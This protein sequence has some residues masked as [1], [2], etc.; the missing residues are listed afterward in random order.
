MS[1]AATLVGGMV[2]GLALAAPP[3]P[4]NAVIATESVLRGW[5]AGFRAGLGAMLADVCFFLL[6]LVGLVAFVQRSPAVRTVLFVAGGLL[7]LYFAYGAVA[8]ARSFVDDDVDEGK[9]FRKAFVL[10]LTNPFQIAF[11]LTVGVG[12]LEPGQ[13]DVLAALP[14]VGQSLA[15]R[16]V[17]QTG[18]PAIIVGLFAG[19]VAWI[20]GFPAA[21]VSARR[22]VESVAPVVAWLSAAVLAGSGLLFLA[23]AASRL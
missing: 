16:A 7:M 1:L 8:S 14:V 2:F 18:E 5:S 15:G 20:L 11:W 22:R 9:G 19:V 23:E 10:A 4:M 17:V 3:G 21:L 12:L 6:A 13:L